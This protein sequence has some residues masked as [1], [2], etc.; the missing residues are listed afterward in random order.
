MHIHKSYELSFYDHPFSDSFILVSQNRNQYLMK[1]SCSY[2]PPTFV[3]FIPTYHPFHGCRPA[4]RTGAL[5]TFP[6]FLARVLLKEGDFDFQA[7]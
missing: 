6:L 1:A 7:Q 4:S 5:P 3:P 2:G